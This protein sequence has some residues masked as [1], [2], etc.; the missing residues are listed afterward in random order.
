M[1]TA[2]DTIAEKVQKRFRNIQDMYSR[3]SVD[4]GLDDIKLEKWENL[5]EVRTYTTGYLEQ[6]KVSPC[7]DTV[8]MALLA[9]KAGR[10]QGDSTALVQSSSLQSVEIGGQM[11]EWRPDRPIPSFLLNIEVLAAPVVLPL[12]KCSWVVP[13]EKSKDFVGRESI[14]TRLLESVPPRADEYRCQQVII[15]GLGGIGKTQIALE[16]AFRVRKKYQDCSIFWVPAVNATSFENAYRA[17]DAG[18]WLL[19][20][21]NADDAKLLFD[22]MHLADYLPSNSKGS[23][24]FTTRHHHI[25]SK[26][27]IPARDAITIKEMSKDKALALLKT[28]LQ[29]HQTYDAESTTKLLEFLTYL[30]P[31]PYGRHLDEDMISLL[32]KDFNDLHRYD[33][34]QNP[35]ATTWLISFRH[36]SRHYPLAADYLRFM[37]FLAEKDVPQSLLPP[38]PSGTAAVEAIGT[39]KAYAFV[40]QRQEKE[41]EQTAYDM[42]RLVQVS[43]LNWLAQA[44]KLEEWATKALQQL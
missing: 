7:I 18:T 37:C 15:E 35:V 1:A 31:W 33:D 27:G 25:V 38:A 16:T 30:Y 19:I 20:I 5:G 4:R 36:I 21:D 13:F 3:F 11:L 44:G 17:I 12:S 34:S 43:M 8:V 23:I 10:G 42:H 29:E 40:T 26:L 6:D 41:Q 9:S 39:L 22:D 28:H 32:S 24:L 14:L 2:S